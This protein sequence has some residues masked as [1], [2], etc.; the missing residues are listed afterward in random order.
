MRNSAN[1][2]YPDWVRTYL[3]LRRYILFGIKGNSL[4]SVH[5]SMTRFDVWLKAVIHISGFVALVRC[6]HN[7]VI[8]MIKIILFASPKLVFALNE[9]SNILILVHKLNST[10]RNE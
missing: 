10:V 2:N 9:F 4:L 8:G 5:E 3:R 6:V 1:G 7:V